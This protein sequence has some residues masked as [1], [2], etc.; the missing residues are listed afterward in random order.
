MSYKE[1]RSTL[2]HSFRSFSSWSIN[3]MAFRTVAAHQE[4]SMWRLIDP[5][6]WNEDRKGLDS[7]QD[8]PP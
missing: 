3:P 8:S 1:E 2:V 5:M 4:A 7:S 6:F